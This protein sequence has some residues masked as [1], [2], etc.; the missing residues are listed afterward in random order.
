MNIKRSLAG[1]FLALC[2]ILAG[3]GRASEPARSDSESRMLSAPDRHHKAVM[4]SLVAIAE[5]GQT[6]PAFNYA[7]N[8][9]DGR[10]ITFGFIGFTT[11]TYDGNI[12]LHRYTALNPNNRLAKYIPALDAIDAG[13]H[14]HGKHDDITRLGGFINA[15]HASLN[16]PFF[17]QSQLEIMDELYWSASVT[18]AR[19]L[20]IRHNITL[21]QIFD[22]SVQMGAAGMADLVTQTNA[23]LGGAPKD[24]I[25]E[26]SWL[27]AFL[28]ARILV[29]ARDPVWN[30]SVD[31][32][33]MYRRLLATGNSALHPPFAV[34]CY[35]LPFTVTGERV[36]ISFEK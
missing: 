23:S 22:A 17:Q 15:V 21:A 28:D 29:L 33:H 6:T 19:E 25:D 1:T 16:D 27:Q 35:G 11:G 8:L 12:W 31:R 20:G 36:S 32:V 5:N 3:S 13:P 24:G 10:G 30:E 14:P 34:T 26:F 7:E 18:M 2:M 4:L 9:H